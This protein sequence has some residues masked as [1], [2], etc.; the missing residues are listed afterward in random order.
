MASLKGECDTVDTG[1]LNREAAP[2]WLTI[3]LWI[4][5][6]VLMFAAARY[7]ERTGPTYEL[8]GGFELAGAF[9]SYELIRSGDSRQDALVV[10]PSMGSGVSATLNFRRYPTDD[11]FT[12][13]TFERESGEMVASLPRQPA[14]GKLEYFVAIDAPGGA[15]R[16]PES[17][18]ETIIIRFKDPVPIYVLVPHIIMM[19]FALLIGMRAALSAMFSPGNMKKLAWV[20]L[21][22]MT[23]GG[24]ILGPI[25]QKYAF[26]AFWTGIPLGWD[27]TDNKT[28]IMWVV[29]AGVCGLFLWKRMQNARAERIAVI[30]AAVVMVVVY[31]IPHSLKGSELDYDAL[32][33]GAPASG[34]VRTGQP[35]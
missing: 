15:I 8:R 35:G 10:I 13:V 5:A 23:V 14:A 25:V 32:D 31:L 6:G 29:W 9:Y 34:A 12:S 22:L 16:I 19:F 3:A 2:L 26:G 4:A 1:S 17:A 27:L 20:T 18:D 30:L 11:D 28:L 24:L 21:A 33:A 7:Q